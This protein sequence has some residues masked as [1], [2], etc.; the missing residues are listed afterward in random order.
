MLAGPFGQRQ[1]SIPSEKEP[2][3]RTANLPIGAQ[4]LEQPGRKQRVAILASFSFL[5]PDLHSGSID[6]NW[7]K[8]TRL[9]EPQPRSIH[10][11]QKRTM[12]G[13]DATDPQQLFQFFD[14]EDLWP[15]H[16]FLYGRQH[17]PQLVHRPLEYQ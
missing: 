6:M 11:H 15:M 5:D 4:L 12:L 16:C 10:R 8:A 7:F 17:Q 14:A 2:R 1:L 13:M 3:P 9:I